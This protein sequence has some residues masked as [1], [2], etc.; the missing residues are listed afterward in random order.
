MNMIKATS[1]ALASAVLVSNAAS[2]IDGPPQPPPTAAQPHHYT[3]AELDAFW[4]S[5]SGMSVRSIELLFGAHLAEIGCSTVSQY[6]RDEF[7][8]LFDGMSVKAFSTLFR[9]ALDGKCPR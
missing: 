9:T 7:A 1:I 5:T 6:T 2:A 8:H 4:S 3:R